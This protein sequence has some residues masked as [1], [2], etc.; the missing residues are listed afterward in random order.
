MAAPSKAATQDSTAAYIRGL[1]AQHRVS[2][3]QTQS[4]T[5][6]Q[7]TTRPADDAIEPDGIECTLFAL[8]RA[9]HIDL[10]ELVHLQ[11]EYLREAKP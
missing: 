5:Q 6:A 7:H 11:M 4:D 1:A 8:H 3:V 10:R 2:Y 9:G